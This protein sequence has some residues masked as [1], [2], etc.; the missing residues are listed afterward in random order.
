MVGVLTLNSDDPSSN[1]GE[2]INETALRT[3]TTALCGV[4]LIVFHM[5]SW[6]SSCF[7]HK[8]LQFDSCRQEVLFEQ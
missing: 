6:Q 8:S 4:L 3:K 7:E 2:D 1:P 5:D